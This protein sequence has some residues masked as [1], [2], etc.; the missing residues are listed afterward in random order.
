MVLWVRGTGLESVTTVPEGMAVV[1]S[2][3]RTREIGT[4]SIPLAMMLL[5]TDWK[6]A[7]DTSVLTDG[8]AAMLWKVRIAHSPLAAAAS[9]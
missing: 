3:P 6:V 2:C 5:I 4:T 8:V 9:T 1:Q 7:V